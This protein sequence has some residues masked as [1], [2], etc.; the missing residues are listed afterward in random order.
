MYNIGISVHEDLDLVMKESGQKK[1]E[2]WMKK[3]LLEKE[4]RLNES[5]KLLIDAIIALSWL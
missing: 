3:K 5:W 2:I 1:S 4:A